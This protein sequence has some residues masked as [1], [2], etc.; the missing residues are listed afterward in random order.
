MNTSD[1]HDYLTQRPMGY[2]VLR[3]LLIEEPTPELLNFLREQDLESLFPPVAD[4]EFNAALTMIENALSQSAFTAGDA[5]FEDLHW[6]FTR[7]FIG[8]ETPPAP[9][10]ESV[11]VSKDKLLFQHCTREVKAVYQS[12]G[13]MMEEGE[14]EAADHIGYELDFMFQQSQSVAEDLHRG[15]SLNGAVARLRAQCDFLSQHLLAF[16]DEFCQNVQTHAQTD[17]YRGVALLLPPFLKHDVRRLNDAWAKE[18]DLDGK[19]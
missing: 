4:A 7:L 13:W 11:Y 14:N 5:A 1:V 17:F 10:W 12:F 19:R 2:D 6:D 8:P 3:R 15:V 16:C 9:P 18:A